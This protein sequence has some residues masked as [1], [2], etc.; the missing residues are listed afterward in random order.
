LL[1]E[2]GWEAVLR[3]Q[4]CGV[5]PSCLLWCLWRERNDRSFED[6]ERTTTDLK[7]FFF[8]SKKRFIKKA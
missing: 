5:V 7:S 1:V 8:I 2:E 6:S 4:L 3:A